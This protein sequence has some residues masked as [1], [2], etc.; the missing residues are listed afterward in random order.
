MKLADLMRLVNLST[1]EQA[2]IGFFLIC[3]VVAC[4]AVAFH[5]KRIVRGVFL[6]LFFVV[7]VYFGLTDQRAWPFTH[8]GHYSSPASH[9]LSYR[10]MV[11]ADEQGNEIWFDNRCVPMSVHSVGPSGALMRM[12][13]GEESE[14]SRAAR[15]ILERSNAYRQVV[16]SRKVLPA[17]SV[18]S[19]LRA[20][21]TARWTR[22]DMTAM[23]D[24]TEV[25]I[26]NVRVVF[27]NDGSAIDES[28]SELAKVIPGVR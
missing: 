24:F 27:S 5:R 18:K 19:V 4:I 20:H 2:H 15:Y 13:R 22:A 12:F 11:L 3:F 26:Y 14:R 8:W 16:L 6:G 17:H 21:R 25:R 23:G 9:T 1:E 28:T 10:H 7:L